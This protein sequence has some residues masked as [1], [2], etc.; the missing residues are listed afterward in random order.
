M[1]KK[2]FKENFDKV[3]KQAVRETEIVSERYERIISGKEAPENEGELFLAYDFLAKIT[4][5]PQRALKLA[6]EALKIGARGGFLDE[7]TR[8]RYI[9]WIAHLKEDVRNTQGKRPW[10]KLF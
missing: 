6:E 3:Y 10:W 7:Y 1:E 9:E 8:N 5:N 4:D 2:N